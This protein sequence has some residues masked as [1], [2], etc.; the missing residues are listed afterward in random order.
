MDF[1]LQLFLALMEYF[2]GLCPSC[3]FGEKKKKSVEPSE[4]WEASTS[5]QMLY[6]KLLN[7]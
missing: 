4:K 7:R 1:L 3:R 6:C 2:P 5:N